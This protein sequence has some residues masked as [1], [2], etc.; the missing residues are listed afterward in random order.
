MYLT[1]SVYTFVIL[2]PHS[3]SLSPPF[4][5]RSVCS[6]FNTSADIQLH[7]WADSHQLAELCAKVESNRC[8]L[9]VSTLFARVLLYIQSMYLYRVH[10]KMYMI[11]TKLVEKDKQ[12]NTNQI[13]RQ[14]LKNCCLGWDSNPRPSVI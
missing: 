2:S 8:S 3:L 7:K 14:F 11:K 13:A 10:T 9:I 5:L 1:T 4:L 12:S 6:E